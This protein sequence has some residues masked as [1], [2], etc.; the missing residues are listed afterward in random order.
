MNRLSKP[1]ILL[2]IASILLSCNLLSSISS[3]T[4]NQPAEVD[5]AP[6]DVET[7]LPEAQIP[8]EG[9]ETP[10]PSQPPVPL[11]QTGDIFIDHTTTDITLIPEEWLEAARE[12]VA[13]FYG[14]TSHGSQLITGA[15]FLMEKVDPLKYNLVTDSETLPSNS[16]PPAMRIFDD[17][18]WGWDADSF[19]PTAHERLGSP[20]G[21]PQVNVFMWSWCGEMSSEDTQVQRYLDMM[22]ELENE[23]PS[24]RFVYMT[25]HTDGGS[26]TLARNNEIVRSYARQNHKILFDFAD[27]ESWDPAGKFYQDTNDSCPWCVSWCL[28][29]PGQCLNLPAFDSECAHSNGFNCKLKGQAFWWLAARLAGW[30]NQ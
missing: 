4:E 24:V 10:T 8:E 12:N 27:I 19:L 20:D 29:H 17:G 1:V 7:S 28:L 3:Q 14:H 25:G 5:T 30:N 6:E 13:W 21:T 18:S 23:Y 22:S 2:M 11:Q 16:D 15:Y 26:E 9:E